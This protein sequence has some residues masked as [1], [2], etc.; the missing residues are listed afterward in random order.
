MD[1]KSENKTIRNLDYYGLQQKYD[2][3]YEQ[4]KTNKSFTKLFD[5]IISEE[6]I[7][8]AYRNIKTNTGSQ[9]AG[10][11][12]RTIKDLEKLTT[13][14]LVEM[15]RK[16]L[17]NYRPYGVK[18]VEIPKPDGN[19]R[20]LG[21]PCIIDRLI[22]Q[23]ILQVLEPICE[24]KF[25][26]RSNGFRPNR[27][28]E[29][30][31]AQVYKMIHQQDLHF[32]VSVDIKGFFDNVNHKKLMQQLWNIGI[33]D[34]KVL[35]IIKA[36]LK[37]PIHM[38][39]GTICNPDKGTPQGG[40]LSPLLANIVLNDLDWWIASQWEMIPTEHDYVGKV[41]KNGIVDTGHKYRALRKTN[42]KEI[43][44]VRYADDFV[45]ACRYYDDAR[46]IK[47]ATER[48]L[49][50]QLKLNINQDKS[51]IVNVETQSFN[52][53]GFKIGTKL[54]NG[55]SVV[56]SHVCDKAINRMY[57][58]LKELIKDIQTCSDSK[59]EYQF[60]TRY[61]VAVMGYHNYYKIAT[62]VN[63]DL[64]KLGWKIDRI[65]KNRLKERISKDGIITEKYI[66]KYYGKSKMI[67]F[68][69]GHTIIPIQYIQSYNPAFKKR[70]IN[71]YTPEG[72]MEIYQ[73]RK[74]DFI[75]VLT[76]MKV[77]SN[78][79]TVEYA[80]NRISKYSAQ[81]GKCAITGIILELDD[82]HCHHI[83][84]KEFGG[85]DKFENLVI[86]HKDIHILIH[87]TDI[88]TIN[89]YIQK[90]NLN[91]KQIDKVNKYRKLANNSI[92]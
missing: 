56:Q 39:D 16:R 89:N 88:N 49:K 77:A 33:R 43:Y 20:P 34:K 25:Y 40:I 58:K 41:N 71:K 32:I 66:E 27:S 79:E 91:K 47:I 1:N 84:P 7:V 30:A 26:E 85:N 65:M 2:E 87:A 55:K 42:L 78:S 13:E 9:T 8:L 48:W 83:I 18:R 15:V 82:I 28:A 44:I 70:S 17:Y 37:A 5:L 67:R 69:H 4:S 36:I 75:N 10:V 74:V 61:N 52:Y 14:K 6:N 31:I 63:L 73:N 92:I 19:K 50:E 54:K 35:S 46:R 38:P 29:N 80:D 21:I 86:V 76:M 59:S 62:D 3:L 12:K 23:C 68:I 45:I 51:K 60:I 22:Q 57:E 11:D 90:L 53:L 72:R 81:N 64:A 24:A